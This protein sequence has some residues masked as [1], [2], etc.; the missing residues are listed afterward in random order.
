MIDL[1][2]ELKQMAKVY[3]IPEKTV[4]TWWRGAVRQLWSSSPFKR[5]YEEDTVD[6]VVN[7]N[8]RT[9]K[10]YPIVKRF[11]CSDCGVPYGTGDM[12]LDHISGE[13]PMKTLA[14]TEQFFKSIMLSKPDELQWMCADKK[15][16]VNKKKYVY[17]TGCHSVKTLRE[18]NPDMSKDEAKARKEFTRIKKYDGVEK[19]LDDRSIK[20]LPK[21]KK[22]Q[23]ALLLELILKEYGVTNA[24]V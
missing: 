19:G 5:K 18:S 17:A 24:K 15:R 9:K 22:D 1:E 11:T 14:D 6:R 13:N 10:R 20:T 2:D 16:I 23:E 21:F 8:P 12:Q 3:N 4:A 7:T